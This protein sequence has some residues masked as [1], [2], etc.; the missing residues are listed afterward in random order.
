MSSTPRTRYCIRRLGVAQSLA[1]DLDLGFDDGYTISVL[2]AAYDSA[3]QCLPQG[4]FTDTEPFVPLLCG[5]PIQAGY[6]LQMA[7][8]E[9]LG[10]HSKSGLWLVRKSTDQRCSMPLNGMALRAFEALLVV[11]RLRICHDPRPIDAAL[12]FVWGMPMKQIDTVL[13]PA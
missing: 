9:I 5:D 11:A 3:Q 4:V 2:R 7:A 12:M 6:V 8:R 1:E 13:F 10:V